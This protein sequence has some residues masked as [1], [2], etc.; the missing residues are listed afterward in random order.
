M[1]IIAQTCWGIYSTPPDSLAVNRGR[2]RRGRG[3]KGL[4]IGREGREKRKGALHSALP[5]YSNP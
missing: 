4:G 5:A 2:E 1:Q 3:G